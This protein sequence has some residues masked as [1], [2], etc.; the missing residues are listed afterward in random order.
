MTKISLLPKI[1]F[2]FIFVV[3]ASLTAFASEEAQQPSS[4]APAE[5]RTGGGG[6]VTISL[7]V[8][9]FSPLFANTPVAEVNGE[10][11]TLRELVVQSAAMHTDM[12]ERQASSEKSFV[13]LLNRIVVT[14][15]ILI[16]ARN[17][18]FDELPEVREAVSEFS[19]RSLRELLVKRF[20][21]D[22][23]IK[24]DERE[25]DRLY[26]MSVREF[27][28]NSVLFKTE[29]DA[30]KAAEDIRP[31]N[32]DEIADKLV[33]D[34]KAEGGGGGKY[35]KTGELAP[36]VFDAAE[37]MKIGEVGPVTLVGPGYV[38]FKL[39]DERFPDDPAVLEQSKNTVLN[40]MRTEALQKYVASLE[41]KYAKVKKSFFAGVDFDA[42]KAGFDGLLKDGRVVAT[43][44]GEDP[45][46][47]A[48]IAKAFQKKLFHG[49]KAAGGRLNSS[50]VAV[51]EDLLSKRVMGKEARLRGF[52]RLEEFKESVDEFENS[53]LFGK[54][55]KDVIAPDIKLTKDELKAYYDEHI[56]EYSSEERVLV[57]GLAFYKLSD[58]E[59]ALRKLTA[60]TDFKWLSAN[61]EG[62]A[63][64]DAKGLIH[65]ERYF[66]SVDLFPEGMKAA[67]TGTKPGDHRLYESPEGL[68]YVLSVKDV[69]PPDPQ[70]F[71]KVSRAIAEK[72]FNDKLS[73][74]LN[75]WAKKLK[76]AYETK[77]FVTNLK[78]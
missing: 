58:A 21:E 11:I 14:K 46:T 74:A 62:Q 31:D 42:D 64:K 44:K 22:T 15:L 4:I 78:K 33:T 16:E 25:V 17:I 40:R 3:L 73:K 24:L 28:L 29:E 61:A 8:P 75:E 77:I 7:S 32:F 38:I 19:N 30:K 50:K 68:Y 51:L 72:V 65:F 34:G 2:A 18:G 39:E 53:L 45:V 12:G 55:V 1:L 13:D 37:K 69:M 48:D 49:V 70:P 57:D 35:F 27:K 43:V 20:L 6:E 59:E 41:K 71:D 60:G 47:V 36:Q 9:I 66:M 54:F 56:K 23:E 63:D 5:Q 76:G 26:K 52:D 10:P 67:L